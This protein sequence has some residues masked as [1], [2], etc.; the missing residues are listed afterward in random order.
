MATCGVPSTWY[1]RGQEGGRGPTRKAE[2]LKAEPVQ[3]DVLENYLQVCRFGS[4]LHHSPAVSLA[5]SILAAP[6]IA[7][8]RI[9]EL[10]HRLGRQPLRHHRP[11]T[12]LAGC[13]LS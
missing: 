3:L 4:A 13:R 7:D 6:Q 1:A 8:L 10:M 2:R 11:Q 5:V 9:V 12:E